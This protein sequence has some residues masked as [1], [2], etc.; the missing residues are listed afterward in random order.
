MKRLK[1]FGIALL[2]CVL[3]FPMMSFIND[4][5]LYDLTGKVDGKY[6]VTIYLVK[7]G[8]ELRGKMFYHSTI[9]KNGVKP[10]SYLYLHGTL[11]DDQMNLII[12]DYD[13]NTFE[14]WN[15]EFSSGNRSCQLEGLIIKPNGK[16][17]TISAEEYF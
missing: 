5:Q 4:A 2:V 12:S 7:N 8:N 10:T 15:G 16:R 11:N 3:L 1:N 17:M 9:V 6:P 13:G 14:K